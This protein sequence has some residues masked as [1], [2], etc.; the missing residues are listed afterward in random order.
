MA[1]DGVHSDEVN[2]QVKVENDAALIPSRKRAP[3]ANGEEVAEHGGDG[4]VRST[5]SVLGSFE[6]VSMPGSS[7]GPPLAV[8]S[9]QLSREAAELVEYA[10][11]IP[12]ARS[13]GTGSPASGSGAQGS[14]AFDLRL[15]GAGPSSAG[16]GSLASVTLEAIR[17]HRGPVAQADSSL[18]KSKS[19]RLEGETTPTRERVRSG[20][21]WWRH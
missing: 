14:P 4:H 6:V 15:P 18:P 8:V 13:I 11:G 5:G 2:T 20:F 17:V 16:S 19:P 7:S 12:V 9:Q 1:N 21:C 10:T 3:E